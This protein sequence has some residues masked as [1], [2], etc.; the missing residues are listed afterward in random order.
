MSSADK[1]VEDC[2]VLAF[3]ALVMCFSWMRED[4]NK[5]FT[6]VVCFF[7]CVA[8][9]LGVWTSVGRHPHFEAQIYLLL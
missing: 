3:K 4:S 1:T 2:L 9:C 5:G 8:S 6:V 7:V